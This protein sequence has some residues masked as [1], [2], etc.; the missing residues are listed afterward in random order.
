MHLGQVTRNEHLEPLGLS[1]QST[2][3][4]L[5]FRHDVGF[6]GLGTSQRVPVAALQRLLDAE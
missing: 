2:Q 5:I 1:Y 3:L 6:D 4:L